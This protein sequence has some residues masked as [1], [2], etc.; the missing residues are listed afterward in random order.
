MHEHRGS[1]LVCGGYYYTRQ[2]YVLDGDKWSKHSRLTTRYREHAESVRLEGKTCIL[3][4]YR[5]AGSTIE[6]LT[7]DN[8]WEK[9]SEKV[10]GR[11]VYKACSV[12]TNSTSILF[13][14]GAMDWTQMIERVG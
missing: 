8:V 12:R 11:G 6:C 5:D 13:I 10:P 2:C 3:G 14:G 7:D 1:I 4:G 9:S